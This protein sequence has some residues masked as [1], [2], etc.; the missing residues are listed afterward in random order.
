MWAQLE[1]EKHAQ[2]PLTVNTKQLYEK[3]FV[4]AEVAKNDVA[5]A[6]L[7]ELNMA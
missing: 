5:V 7:D 4:F 3:G 2:A 1:E 6:D